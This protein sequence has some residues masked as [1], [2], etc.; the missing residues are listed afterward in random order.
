MTTPD[1]L[2]L[3]VSLI[4]AIAAVFAW[5]AARGLSSR[6]NDGARDAVRLET[7]VRD[8]AATA[9]R[10]AG[11]QAARGRDELAAA[12]AR[13]GQVQTAQADVL[14]RQLAGQLETF[15]RQLEA[16]TRLGDE[17]Q[18][19][20][21]AEGRAAREQQ[22]QV[23]SRFGEALATQFNGLSEASA[24]RMNELRG[25]VETRLAAIQADNTA[26]LDEMRRTVDEKLND[27]LQK[28][29]GESFSRVAERLEQVQRGLGEM[30]S[31]AADV[32][33]LRR[34]LSGV[35]TRGTWGEVQLG[36]LL[37]QMLVA[38]QYEANKATRP[39]STERVE[40]AIRLPGRDAID[41]PVWLPIDAK[42]PR[43]DYERLLDAQERA[44]AAGV[45]E[46]GKQLE[47]RIREEAR[48]I[49][50]KYIEPPHTTDFALLF[51]PT[52]GLY[53]EVIRRPGLSEWLQRECRVTVAGPTTLSALL[54][55]LQMG[56]RTLAIQKRS[57]E[58]WLT[59]GEVK[60]EFDKFG[61]VLGKVKKQLETVQNSIGDAETR[62]RQ[63]SRKL[64]NVESLP[65]VVVAPI[66]GLEAE[67]G[68]S[69]D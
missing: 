63:I 65:G 61:G 35:K 28:R 42:F 57:S 2:L 55:S 37:E 24:Q 27:T 32:G 34:V 45:E 60:S 69:E 41:T 44:D 56:F 16:Q 49:R 47:T 46:A 20:S 22:A 5:L 59:L 67:E 15:A 21:L 66:L 54:N 8:E 25:T 30:Q 31:L 62:T 51:L 18:Q 23:L 6:L 26:K 10:E 38:D 3:A 12:L 64:K 19:A 43:E 9:R 58:V 40:Y 4:A 39:R 53:A 29:L 14:G 50:D 33:G 48:K 1:L 36:S 7:A 17:R 13:F 52:E 68:D 11:E